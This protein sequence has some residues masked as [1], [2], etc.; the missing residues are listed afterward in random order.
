MARKPRLVPLWSNPSVAR[1]ECERV[2]GGLFVTIQDGLMLVSARRARQRETV[3]WADIHAQLAA[4]SPGLKSIREMANASHVINARTM[5]V[6][7]GFPQGLA[8]PFCEH[9]H[10]ITEVQE[11]LEALA[12]CVKDELAK[13]VSLGRVRDNETAAVAR[14]LV[15]LEKEE[16]RR[17]FTGSEAG[18]IEVA[19]LGLEVEDRADWDDVRKRWDEAIREARRAPSPLGDIVAAA[20]KIATIPDG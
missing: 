1:A 6:P 8:R 12:R 4:L 15:A 11:K 5:L 17:P 7:V 20:R 9:L 13:P 3:L 14:F 18:L 10:T 19:C 16:G 2:F